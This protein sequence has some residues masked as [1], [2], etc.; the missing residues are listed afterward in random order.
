MIPVACPLYAVLEEGGDQTLG[1]DGLLVYVL[2][3]LCGVS[4]RRLFVV[5]RGALAG[6]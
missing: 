6:P 4:L 2:R 1:D 5:Q 3:V